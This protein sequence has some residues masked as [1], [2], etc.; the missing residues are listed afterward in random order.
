MNLTLQL[1]QI[2]QILGYV[3]GKNDRV[4]LKFYLNEI[5]GKNNIHFEIEK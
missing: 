3:Y 4:T 5:N 1:Q 2:T